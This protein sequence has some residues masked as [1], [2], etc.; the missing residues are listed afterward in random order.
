M[1]AILRLLS[2]N[3]SGCTSEYIVL[4]TN[5]PEPM[6]IL[7]ILCAKG[8]VR[9]IMPEHGSLIPGPRFRITPKGLNK[10]EEAN[11]QTV[12]I[13]LALLIST[14]QIEESES[15]EDQVS[16]LEGEN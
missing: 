15:P 9:N 12:H 8:F 3:P 1:N 16:Q 4:H 10:L 13:P 14:F 2:I 11:M 7:E 6:P 5:I